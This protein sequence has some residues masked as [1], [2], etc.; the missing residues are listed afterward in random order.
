MK[1]KWYAALAVMVLMAGFAVC[2][3]K[4]VFNDAV[5]MM[6]KFLQRGR[7][8]KIYSEEDMNCIY[9]LATIIQGV[10]IEND[11]FSIGGGDGSQEFP[12]DECSISLDSEFNLIIKPKK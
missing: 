9:L 4:K 3:E 10:Q 5:G 6:D 7:Y 8:I 1:K 2:Q 12:F 11:G